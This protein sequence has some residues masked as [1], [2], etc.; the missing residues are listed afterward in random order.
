MTFWPEV[1]L[2]LANRMPAQVS[3]GQRHLRMPWKN[4]EEDMSLYVILWWSDTVTALS[5]DRRVL[6]QCQTLTP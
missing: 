1:M 4:K 6:P 2:L 5:K 3:Y